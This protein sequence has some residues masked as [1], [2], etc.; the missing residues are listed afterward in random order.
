V[1]LAVANFV[2]AIYLA[3]SVN[4]LYGC[5]LRALLPWTAVA[6]VSLC[7]VGGAAIA[8]GIT[9]EA[10]ATLLGAAC[11]TLL[12][13]AVFAALLMATRLEEARILLQRLKSLAPALR[14]R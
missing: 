12:Y 4:R 2:E 1:G 8:F 3:Y 11:G 9:S 7:A 10:R 6:K 14:G 13:G 5:G